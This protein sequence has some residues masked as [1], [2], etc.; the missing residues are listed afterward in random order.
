M[1]STITEIGAGGG[2]V[3]P[4]RDKLSG[5]SFVFFGTTPAGKLGCLVSV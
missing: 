4:D 2:G 1:A 3:S 5:F